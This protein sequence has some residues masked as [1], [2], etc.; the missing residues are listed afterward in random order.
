MFHT[1]NILIALFCLLFFLSCTNKNE[2]GSKNNPILVSLIPTKEA[3]SL[4]LAGDEFKKSME[5]KTGY[6]FEVNVP[7]SYVAVVEALGS[8]RADVAFLTTSSFALALKKY[9]IEAKFIS[10]SADGKSTYR[11]QFIVPTSSKINTLE[12]LNGKKIAFV[13]PSSASGYILAAHLLKQKNIKPSEIVFAGKHDAVVT[14]VY[15]GQVDAGATFYTPP[16]DGVMK[17]ARRLV[18]TQYP[19]VESKIKILGFTEELANDAIVFRED[20]ISE[21]KTKVENA[22]WEWS[23]TAEGKK[24]LK[25]LNNGTALKKVT[26][27]DYEKDLKMLYD[28]EEDL[29]KSEKK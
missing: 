1:K 14:M 21:L 11:G 2:K 25:D 4:L 26:N 9:K 8:K 10:V 24:T 19:D 5:Q 22:I 20:L 15:Q 17:D 28:I 18:K 23:Q 29:K 13:D 16:E 3:S 27:A 6:S 12:Q 7:N